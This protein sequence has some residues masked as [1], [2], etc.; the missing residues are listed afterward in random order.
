M[1]QDRLALIGAEVSNLHAH[2]DR[3]EEKIKNQEAEIEELR[4]EIWFIR[5]G[6]GRGAARA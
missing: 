2:Y 1:R 6:S 4:G 3:L 5:R